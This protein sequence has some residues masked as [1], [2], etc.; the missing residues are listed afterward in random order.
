MLHESSAACAI[1]RDTKKQGRQQTQSHTQ[2]HIQHTLV[3]ISFRLD[4]QL[5]KD[6]RMS[7]NQLK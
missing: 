6:Y 5:N 3:G 4:A 2:P 1:Q 7:V